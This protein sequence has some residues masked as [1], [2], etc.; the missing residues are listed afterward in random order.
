MGG[1]WQ[2]IE[3]IGVQHETEADRQHQVR[4]LNILSTSSAILCTLISLVALFSR[5][6]QWQLLCQITA[7][8]CLLTLYLNGKGLLKIAYRFLG[9]VTVIMTLGA[10]VIIGDAGHSE[11]LFVLLYLVASAFSRS[12]R[13][14]FYWLCLSVL[15]IFCCVVIYEMY[16]PLV[17]LDHPVLGW[18]ASA[19]VSLL[20]LVFFTL[21]NRKIVASKEKIIREKEEVLKNESEKRKQNSKEKQIAQIALRKNELR[22]KMVFD[23]AFEGIIFM[24]ARTSRPVSFNARMPELFRCTAEEIHNMRLKDFIV[25]NQPDGRSGTAIIGSWFQQ[26]IKGKSVRE[27]WVMRKMDQSQMYVEMTCIPLP[28]PQQNIVVLFLRDI[29]QEKEEEENRKAVLAELKEVNE[30]LGRFAYI[31]SHDLKAPLRAIGSLAD[32]LEADYLDKLDDQG[33]ELVQLINGRVRRMHNLIEGV[34]SYSRVSRDKEEKSV[35]ETRH[36]VEQI[37]YSLAPPDH[38]Q[39]EVSQNLHSLYFERTRLTQVF[40]NL[41]SN[42]ITFMDKEEARVYVQSEETED[43]IKFMVIDNGPGIEEAYFHKIFQIFQT[44]QA[45]DSFETMGIGLAIVKKIVDRYNGKVEVASKKGE[46]STFTISFP[47][48]FIQEQEKLMA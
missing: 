46:G 47:K 2:Y 38:I 13:E 29:S 14:S 28:K 24:D 3:N 9:I 39:I 11:Q 44:L 5:A 19:C 37:I 1:I 18:G 42:A 21:H 35:I 36:L 22:Y 32:W 48:D 31:V 15:S 23:H 43:E 20:V 16:E 6:Y 34:L 25:E 33:Q 8:L 26:V 27:S 7:V 4:F 41:I 45:R 30:E 10:A 12:K 17:K 40:Q